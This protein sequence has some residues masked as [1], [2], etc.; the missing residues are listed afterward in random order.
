MAEFG[1]MEE[2]VISPSPEWNIELGVPGASTNLFD[3]TVEEKS[4]YL[5]YFQGKRKLKI[6]YSSDI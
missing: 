3:F 2:P 1:S 6:Q 5:E 4:W